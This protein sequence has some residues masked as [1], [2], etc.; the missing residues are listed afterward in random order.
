MSVAAAEGGLMGRPLGPP[1]RHV[2]IAPPVEVVDA[3]RLYAKRLKIS[4]TAV[5]ELA[6]RR[7]LKERGVAIAGGKSA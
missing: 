3:V 7:F 1:R 2:N 4:Q 6:I 5:Y